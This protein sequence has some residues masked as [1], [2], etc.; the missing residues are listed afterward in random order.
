MNLE[1]AETM[2]FLTMKE[3]GERPGGKLY[4]DYDPRPQ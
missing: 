4:F 1:R 2:A 3:E